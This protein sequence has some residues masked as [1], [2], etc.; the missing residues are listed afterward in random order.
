[1]NKQTKHTFNLVLASVALA[2]GIA[3]IV[4]SIFD[5]NV[6]TNDLITMLAVAIVALGIY[7]L[8]KEEDKNKKTE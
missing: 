6:T 4:L 7:T 5:E 8:N 1:M 3:V 2:M